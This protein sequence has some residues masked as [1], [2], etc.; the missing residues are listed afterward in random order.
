MQNPFPEL[1]SNLQKC[2]VCVKKEILNYWNAAKKGSVLHIAVFAT[3][4]TLAIALIVLCVCL[5]LPKKVKEAATSVSL[6]P[7]TSAAE[8]AS[9]NKDAEKLDTKVYDGVVLQQTDDAGAAYIDETLFVGDSNT[10]R[11][12]QYGPATLK[13]TLGASSMGIQHVLSTPCMFFSGYNQPV[14]VPKAV[15]MM[16]PR[17][18]V[19]NYGTNNTM[20]DADTF[21]TQYQTAAKAIHEAYP[22]AELIIAAVLPVAKVRQYPAITMQKIDEFNQALAALAK[23]DGYRFLNTTEVIQDASGYG[24]AEYM[25]PDGIHLNDK[26][27]AAYFAYVRTHASDAADK[28]GTLEKVP[29]HLATPDTLFGPPIPVQSEAEE[30]SSSSEANEHY[31]FTIGG[32]TLAVGQS[33][34][35]N[36]TTYQPNAQKFVEKYGS[37]ATWASSNAGVVAI[38]GGGKVTGVS[39]GSVTITCNIGGMT[40]SATVTV[41]GGHT[42]KFTLPGA[43]VAATCTTDGYTPYLCEA[44]DGASE[45]RDIIPKLGHAWGATDPATGVQKCTRCAATQQDP[46]WEPVTPPTPPP[47]PSSTPTPPPPP[48]PPP[49][50]TPTPPP[51]PP[52]TPSST[53]PPAP[54][55]DPAPPSTPLPAPATSDNGTPAA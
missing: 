1:M 55:P 50:S 24:K 54:A 26:G 52:P 25:M 29:N 3:A 45:N 28:R 32:A 19:M 42:H 31:G 16:Q 5:L 7:A 27:M 36:A 15:A 2:A 34:Q 22:D 11:M 49:S 40:A 20:W 33:A 23:E 35:L 44:N 21:K 9:Y 48:P 51:P 4:G 30:A 13:N 43:P 37:A 53:P 46:A 17:R 12:V 38:D 41:T 10:A 14:L 47:P 18:I 39:A 8:D 6:P